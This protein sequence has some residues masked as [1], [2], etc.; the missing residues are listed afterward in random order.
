[1]IPRIIHRIWLGAKPLP[2][3]HLY[4]GETWRRNH[5]DWEMR[6]W[7][8]E[9][10]P[11]LDLGSA[12][13]RGRHYAERANVL[14]YELLRRFGGVYVDTDV[15]S[16]RSIE[17]LLDGVSAFA[18][19]VRPGTIGN[20][21]LGSTPGHPAFE[22]ASQEASRRVGTEKNSITATGPRFLTGLLRDFPDVKLFDPQVFYPYDWHEKRPAPSEFGEAYAAHHW[23][24]TGR[25]ESL[26]AAGDSDY[27]RRKVLA[28]RR[29]RAKA[30]RRTEKARGKAAAA[31]RR[32]DRLEQRLAAI[33][34]SLWWRLN[35][36]RLRGVARARRRR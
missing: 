23:A 14:R 24:M 21:V 16:L 4:Y 26:D 1:M 5:R 22:R 28:L 33:E 7:R 8:D 11:S 27:L 36:G 3:E 19:Y 13:E 17:P 35:P 12:L 9:D 29:R 30:D 20:S 31:R 32:A 18:G 6:L 25:E 34:S 10:L 2:E 15:E